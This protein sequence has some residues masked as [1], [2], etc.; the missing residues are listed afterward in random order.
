MQSAAVLVP[1]GVVVVA[2]GGRVPAGM[3]RVSGCCSVTEAILT[4]EATAVVKTPVVG[5]PAGA[6]AVKMRN[7]LFCG[8]ALV[9]LRVPR[10][11]RA[12]AVVVRT[13]VGTVKG[14]LILSVLHP[15]PPPFKFISTRRNC[16]GGGRN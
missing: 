3:V 12:L 6:A 13:G 9:E 2:A 16:D 11:R 8:T 4:G 10:G 15:S 1:G 7:T 5:G 14:R